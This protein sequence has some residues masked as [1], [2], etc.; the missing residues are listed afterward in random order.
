MIESD[1]NL[2]PS[3]NWQT[4]LSP[5]EQQRLS[6]LRVLFHSPKFILLDEFTS[7]VDQETES[8]MYE[9]LNANKVTYLSIAHRDTVR[10][11][12]HIE[13]KILND[14]TYKIIDL[15]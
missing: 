13:L 11:Y 5:G 3:F 6:F 12:H 1:L 15:Y 8:L 7:S 2:K 10:K 9:C 4:T 14:S